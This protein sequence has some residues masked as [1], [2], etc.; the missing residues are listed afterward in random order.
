MGKRKQNLAKHNPNSA[1]KMTR[2]RINYCIILMY[3]V[4]NIKITWTWDFKSSVFVWVSHQLELNCYQSSSEPYMDR[5]GSWIWY[6]T[7]SMTGK[8][9]LWLPLNFDIDGYLEN[10]ILELWSLLGLLWIYFLSLVNPL[11]V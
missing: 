5:C 4:E 3:L 7:D 1:H 11:K 9:E 6:R 10:Y 2:T 8:L